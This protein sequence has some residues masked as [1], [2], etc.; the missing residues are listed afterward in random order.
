MLNLKPQRKTGLGGRHHAPGT[1]PL[2][3]DPVLLLQDAGWAPER[4]WTGA[5]NLAP[6]GFQTPNC[7]ARSDTLPLPL[8]FEKGIL[9]TN[10]CHKKQG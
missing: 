6:T 4:S 1:L 7:P 3:K 9:K 10:S 2:P 8:K 5:E